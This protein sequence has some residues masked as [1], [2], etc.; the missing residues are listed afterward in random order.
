ML[1]TILRLVLAQA[2]AQLALGVLAEA[3]LTYIGLGTQAPATSLGLLL[4][5]AQAFAA[6]RPGLLFVP[7]LVLLL[8]ALALTIVSREIRTAAS[9]TSGGANGAA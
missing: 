9:D 8:L 7:G 2:V 6:G 3:T 5:D 1:P 4:A